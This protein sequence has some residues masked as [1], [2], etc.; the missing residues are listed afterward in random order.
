MKKREPCPMTVANCTFT[1]NTSANEH[2]R[3]AAVA[4]AEAAKANAEAIAEIARALKG[5]NI[6]S[7][8]KI[9]TNPES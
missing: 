5:G 1:G 2:T 8:L 4:L 3:A 7:M 9:V 6:E